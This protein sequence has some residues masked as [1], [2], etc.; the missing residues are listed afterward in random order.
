MGPIP[1]ATIAAVCLLFFAPS[2]A[3]LRTL[4]SLSKP[5]RLPSTTTSIGATAGEEL[6]SS[7][8]LLHAM[9]RTANVSEAVAFW[10]GRG[11]RVLSGSGKVTPSGRVGPGAAFVGYGAYRDTEH[12]A[13]E[14][15][16]LPANAKSLGNTALQFVGVSMLL[17]SPP[18]NDDDA[19]DD[20]ASANDGDVDDPLARFLAQRSLKSWEVEDPDDLFRVRSVASAPG[21]PFARFV[22]RSKSKAA[23]LKTVDFY[24]DVLQMSQV[25]MASEEEKCFRYKPRPGGALVGVPTT[26]VFQVVAEDGDDDEAAAADAA[27]VECFDHLAICCSDIGAAFDHI[28]GGELAPVILE[29]CAMFGTKIM[30]LED[31]NGYKIYLVEE[32]SFRA[33]AEAKE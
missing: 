15:S 11:A 17:P 32:A 28:S 24:C 19:N 3:F 16:P 27:A 18:S 10:E 4:P 8:R 14:L 22:L 9:L 12:F 23:L 21:D 30:G 2:N 31:P 20:D 29:P 6:L 7:S 1:S 33:G 5:F 13:L 26:L 25:G